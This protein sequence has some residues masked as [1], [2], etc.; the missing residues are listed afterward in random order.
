MLWP[1]AMNRL[2]G[3]Q[4]PDTPD[5]FNAAHFN[6]V[7]NFT[8]ARDKRRLGMHPEKM[9]KAIRGVSHLLKGKVEVWMGDWL[10]TITDARPL[11]GP[12]L[13]WHLCRT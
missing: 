6:K 10:E 2:C 5:Y 1:T 12:A 11:H 3:R 9:R 4:T 8:Q 7:A 13:S